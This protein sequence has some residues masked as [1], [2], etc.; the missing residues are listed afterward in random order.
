MSHFASKKFH[1]FMAP[2]T[3]F[4]HLAGE[5]SLTRE[6]EISKYI[7][8]HRN[9][10]KYLYEILTKRIKRAMLRSIPIHLLKKEAK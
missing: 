5:F 4:A 3:K 10:M 8:N 1:L 9:T 2:V 7:E 6:Q